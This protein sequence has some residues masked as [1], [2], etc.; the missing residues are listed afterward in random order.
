[1]ASTP[2]H[3]PQRVQPLHSVSSNAL[4]SFLRMYVLKCLREGRLLASHVRLF[5]SLGPMYL[6][7]CLPYV[8]VLNLG[9]TNSAVLRL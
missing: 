8:T 4:M 1:M 9:M 5:H 7:E 3:V 6:S 2:S